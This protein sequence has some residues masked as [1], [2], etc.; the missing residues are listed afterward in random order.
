LSGLPRPW[1][2]EAREEAEALTILL[3]LPA[4][5]LFPLVVEEEVTATLTLLLVALLLYD[6]PCSA[7]NI[8]LHAV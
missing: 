7:T 1:L 2:T 5:Q 8:E 6:M 3:L 4:T